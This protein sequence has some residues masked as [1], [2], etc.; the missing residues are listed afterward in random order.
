RLFRS[1][2]GHGRVGHQHARRR[3]GGRFRRARNH[4]HDTRRPVDRGLVRVQNH[5]HG[6]VP[7]TEQLRAA[8][9]EPGKTH[10]ASELP[11][12]STTKQPNASSCTSSTTDR[13]SPE[14]P[15][16]WSTSAAFSLSTG[17][18]SCFPPA[19]P[20]AAPSTWIGCSSRAA[21]SK[22]KSFA[23]S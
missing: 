23:V 17:A 1:V 10:H 16:T 13:A 12:R 8:R 3:N 18:A 20:V 5:L 7:H 22:D 6:A 9:L 19:T 2:H 4:G 15:P 11:W 21:S 14:K